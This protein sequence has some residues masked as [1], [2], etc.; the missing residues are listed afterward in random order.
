MIFRT[1][2]RVIRNDMSSG[3]NRGNG[4]SDIYTARCR[5]LRV[6]ERLVK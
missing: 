1:S 2:E 4:Y 5:E 6:F 3:K